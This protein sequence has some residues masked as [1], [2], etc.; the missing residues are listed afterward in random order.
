ML[1]ELRKI[2]DALSDMDC[3]DRDEVVEV[4]G[5]TTDLLDELIA[6]E[7]A[8]DAEPAVTLRPPDDRLVFC[9]GSGQQPSR[10]PKFE[11][12]HFLDCHVC[13]DRVR[14]VMRGRYDR[15]GID[16]LMLQDHDRKVTADA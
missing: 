6:E 12:H 13:G 14:V 2:R 16:N 3:S 8:A 15:S 4:M 11:D 7:E 1:N 9:E 5:W 10:M